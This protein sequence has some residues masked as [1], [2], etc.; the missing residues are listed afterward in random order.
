MVGGNTR[1]GLENVLNAK[2][3]GYTLLLHH[4][5]FNTMEALGQLPMSYS[6]YEVIAQ[7]SELPYVFSGKKSEEFNSFEK[8]QEA[9][10]KNPGSV[11]FGIPG[12]GGTAHMGWEY[13]LAETNTSEMY[14]T[15]PFQGGAAELAAAI[16][17]G[18]VD[19][20]ALAATDAKKYAESGDTIP[21]VVTTK[22]RMPEFPDAVSFKDLGL[23]N[24]IILRTGFFAPPNTPKEVI[25]ILEGAIQKASETEEFKKFAKKGLLTPNFIPGDE[26]RK[27]LDGDQKIY[28]TLAEKIK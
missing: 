16:L 1:I 12:I 19:M 28:N 13:I 6:E 14:K 3:D 22:E 24:E 20:A 7:V 15:I 18:Q 26:W 4:S 10:N 8:Y 17:G 11:T 9:A 2:P 21:L 23:E 5:A 27:V 25:E